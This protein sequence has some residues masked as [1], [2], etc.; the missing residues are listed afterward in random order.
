[1]DELSE[2]MSLAF[3]IQISSF[4]LAL[5]AAMYSLMAAPKSATLV[6]TPRRMRLSVMS[7]KKFSTMLSQ[8]ALVGVKCIES[9]SA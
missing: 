4:G 1:M 9:E 5:Y 2:R 6:N 8:E 7:W 3:A